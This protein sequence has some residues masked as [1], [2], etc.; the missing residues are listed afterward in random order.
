MM[1]MFNN[2]VPRQF[3]SMGRAEKDELSQC[4]HEG[5]RSQDCSG[6]PFQTTWLGPWSAARVLVMFTRILVEEVVLLEE[7]IALTKNF[8][9]RFLRRLPS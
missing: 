5:C 1:N 4:S 7:K 9:G 2:L 8:M 3:L 6:S